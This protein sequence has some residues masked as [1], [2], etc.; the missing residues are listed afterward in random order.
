VAATPAMKRR[1]RLA[2]E[3]LALPPSPDVDTMLAAAAGYS[4]MRVQLERM[5]PSIR[6][7]TGLLVV[8]DDVVYVCCPPELSPLHTRHVVAHELGHMVLEHVTRVRPGATTPLGCGLYDQATEDEAEQFAV[9]LQVQR[10]LTEP[11]ATQVDRLEEVFG[12]MP[13]RR[14]RQRR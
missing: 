9:M 14:Q 1:C 4:G 6:G 2:I 7:V 11:H 3:H 8:V 12:S 10:L 13:T 5:D